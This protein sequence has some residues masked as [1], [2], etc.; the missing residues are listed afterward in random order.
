MPYVLLD[1]RDGSYRVRAIT[2][3]EA[4][5][6]MQQGGEVACVEDRVLA[7]WEHH[8]N[9]AAVFNTMWRSLDNELNVRRSL[10]Y[11]PSTKKP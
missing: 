1:Y 4:D 9:E 3:E 7:A 6:L 5:N 8:R 2:D 11:P 10:T